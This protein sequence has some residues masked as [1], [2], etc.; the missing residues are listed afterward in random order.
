MIWAGDGQMKFDELQAAFP[1]PYD[2]VPATTT[3]IGDDAEGRA[4]SL[5]SKLS[6]RYKMPVFVSMNLDL[7]EMV[8]PLL[9][10]AIHDQMA[11]IES[12]E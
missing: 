8:F 11:T 3:L 6:K 12:W 4:G 5:A 7:D 10:K 9:M 2:P 1:T